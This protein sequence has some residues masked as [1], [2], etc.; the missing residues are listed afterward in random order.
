MEKTIL[1]KLEWPLT[2]LTHYVFL[3]RFIKV[4]IPDKELESLIYFLTELS[5]MNYDT[6]M[7]C[8]SKVAASAVYAARCTLNKIPLWAET[9]KLHTGFCGASFV[10]KKALVQ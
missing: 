1:G 6:K 10:S 3:V 4:S 7:F 2:V 9:L 8:P 5:M